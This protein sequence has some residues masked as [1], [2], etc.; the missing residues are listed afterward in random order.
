MS[1][2]SISEL[3]TD[4]PEG[5]YKIVYIY[6]KVYYLNIRKHQ[7]LSF[8]VFKEKFLLIRVKNK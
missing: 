8:T 5:S 7:T 6:F 4:F 3:Q 2:T 1:L